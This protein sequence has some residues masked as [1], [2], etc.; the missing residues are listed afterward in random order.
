MFEGDAGAIHPALTPK[1]DD[2][3]IVKHRISAFAGT[4]LDMILRAN[5]INTLVLFGIATSGG[6]LSTLT[7][8]ADLDYR[9]FVI[10]DCCADLDAGLHGALVDKFFPSRGD[11]MAADEF[12]ARL[13]PLSS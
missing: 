3:V 12:L 9:L 7:D 2:I 6:V 11:V 10:K 13:A 5:E 1:A 8:A 4:D